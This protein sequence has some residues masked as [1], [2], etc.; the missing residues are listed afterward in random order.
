M[1]DAIMKLFKREKYLSKIRGFYYEN[2]IIKVIT[3][4][5]RCGKSSLMEMIADELV[6]KGVDK[7]NIIYINLD[8]RGYKNI[9]N[10]EQLESLI[11][12]KTKDIKGD[13]YLFIDEIQNVTG[14]EV[15]INAF[16]EE[17]DFSIFITGSNSYLLSG[18]LVTKLT[19]RYLEFELYPLTLD[20]YIEM[21]KFYSIE[22]NSNMLV[23]LNE[24][25]ING[26]FPRSLFFNN[27]QDKRNYISGLIDEI[28]KKD[29]K[30]RVRIRKKETFE[31]VKN[32]IINNFGSTMSINNMLKGLKASNLAIGKATLSRYIQA[33]I[34]AKILY[35]CDRF[36]MKSKKYLSGEK[37][38]Y[39]ADQSFYY[40]TNT[41][42]RINYG[43]SLENIVFLYAKSKDYKISVG[44]IGKLECDFILR[45]IELNYS[46]VQIAYT[47]L[48]SIDTENREYEPLENI[49]D[50]YPKYVMTTDYLFQK[51]NGI[52][53]VNLIDFIKDNLDF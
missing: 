32:Y 5:R 7:N 33:L 37:K 22:V 41:D 14:F 48:A 27:P 31:L 21:K 29:I 13:K 17:G 39:L 42:N 11:D 47:I 30:K 40:S 53:H 24:Y 20:E 10:E 35:E 16:R 19:G 49:K 38:Y 45:D 8:K 3:G 6:E 4:I 44:R 52:K 34:D 1:G 26:G 43:P 23:E 28:F 46:Y 9:K 50:N 25:I 36:D 12:E 15:V 18:E 51:R 2:D